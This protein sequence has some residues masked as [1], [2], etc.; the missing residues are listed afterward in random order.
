MI[1]LIS[2][3][4]RIFTPSKPLIKDTIFQGHNL[5]VFNNYVSQRRISFYNTFRKPTTQN[6]ESKIAQ[7]RNNFSGS[8]QKHTLFFI[9]TI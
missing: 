4:R 9:E 8:K 1:A 5:E 3:S 7:Y 2:Q 6:T